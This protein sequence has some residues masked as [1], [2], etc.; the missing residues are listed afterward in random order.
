MSLFSSTKFEQT[1]R[2]GAMIKNANSTITNLVA[3]LCNIVNEMS[4]I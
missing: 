4:K 2:E 3:A 1:L